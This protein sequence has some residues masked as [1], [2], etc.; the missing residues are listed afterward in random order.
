MIAASE[1]RMISMLERV[2]LD[3]AIAAGHESDTVIEFA[4]DAVMKAVRERCLACMA[5]DTCERWLVDKEA[6]DNAFCP[7]AAVFGELKEICGDSA[8][9]D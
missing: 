2:G 8:E 6:C 1:R 3:P 5:V 7:N 4:I 9:R